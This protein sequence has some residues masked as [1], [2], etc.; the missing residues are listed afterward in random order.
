M[1]PDLNNYIFE[2]LNAVKYVLLKNELKQM[3]ICFYNR[4]A[5]PIERFIFKISSLQQNIK[6]M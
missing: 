1:Y 4:L 3:D 5:K 6:N 2:S